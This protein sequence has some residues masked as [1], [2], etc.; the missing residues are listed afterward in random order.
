[1]R[2]EDEIREQYEFLQGEL[3]SE[4][5]RHENVRRLFTHYKR[6]SVGTRPRRDTVSSVD[7]SCRRTTC[8]H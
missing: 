3:E 6:A 4:Q 1:M 7:D 8:F 2:D 5:M